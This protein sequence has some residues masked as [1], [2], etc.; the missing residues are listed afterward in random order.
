LEE[1]LNDSKSKRR[2]EYERNKGFGENTQAKEPLLWGF[3]CLFEVN[4]A[5][6]DFS[7]AKD[8]AGNCQETVKECLQ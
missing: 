1:S 2:V 4:E 3:C 8:L 6:V 5:A 7:S